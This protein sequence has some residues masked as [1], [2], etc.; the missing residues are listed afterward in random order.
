MGFEVYQIVSDEKHFSPFVCQ[1]CECLCSLD[2]LVTDACSHPFCRSCLESHVASCSQCPTCQQSIILTESSNGEE[3]I[4]SARYIMLGSSAT[5]AHPI[6][7]AQPLAYQLLCAVQVA[8][9][10]Q[11]SKT[12]A[13]KADKEVTMIHT[14]EWIGDYAHFHEHISEHHNHSSASDT[15]LAKIPVK[16]SQQLTS[17]LPEQNSKV[18]TRP[19]MKG[20]RSLSTPS[21]WSGEV[22]EST[23]EF[24]M[25]T[26]ATPTMPYRGDDSSASKDDSAIDM[27]SPR[28]K[29]R[30]S[31]SLKDM[32]MTKTISIDELRLNTPPKPQVTN[33]TSRTP[34]K[35]LGCDATTSRDTPPAMVHRKIS[36]DGMVKGPPPQPQPK[37]T[38][39]IIPVADE[40]FK[41]G[42]GGGSKSK[43]LHG[44]PSYS[45]PKR[46]KR[47][48]TP[49]ASA[50]AA[51]S[52]TNNGDSDLEV[53]YSHALDWNMSIN[54]FGGGFNN[55]NSTSDVN[56]NA[57]TR[58]QPAMDTLLEDEEKTDFQ[59]EFEPEDSNGIGSEQST[60]RIFDKAE[61]LKKQANAKFNKGDF[62]AARTLYT[63]GI[64][65]MQTMTAVSQEERELLSGMHSNRGVTYF[66][67]KKF[68]SCI[69]DCEHAIR[70]DST[71]DKSWIRKWRAHMAL[72][73]FDGAYHCLEKANR[74]IPASKKIQEELAN[75]QQ[76]KELL[77]TARQFLMKKDYE[78]IREVLRP[79][80]TS[81]DNISLLFL[82][83]RADA[84]L[85][86]TE[87]ALEKINKALRFNPMH[88]E[89][90][91]LRGHTLFLAGETEKGAHLLQEAL[92][93]NK[94]SK[95]INK[96]LS[97]CQ[98]THT[99]F[100]KGRASVKRGR[101]AEAVEHFAQAIKDSGNVP[102]QTPLFGSLRIERAEAYLL[103]NRYVDACK[104]CQEVINSQPEHATAWSVRADILVALGEPE[105]AKKELK[106]I[107]KSWG[108]DNPTIGEAFKRVD[109]ELRVRKADD[110]LET[111]LADLESGRAEPIFAEDD[112]KTKRKEG[113]RRN[114][115]S[116]SSFGFEDDID[117]KNRDK[118][119]NTTR[120]SLSR[121]RS[122]SRNESDNE[123][124]P[125]KPRSQSARR[126]EIQKRSSFVPPPSIE[127]LTS[128]DDTPVPER[129]SSTNDHEPSR[130]SKREPSRRRS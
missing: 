112:R 10:I 44:S 83:A 77:M 2:A 17:F 124:L 100:Q 101:Y 86:H 78:Q 51:P 9:I 90:L 28:A 118:K 70:Y 47:P 14:C 24:T 123:L 87:A 125:E 69:E 82:A 127:D 45:G 103:C 109:F 64:N 23:L 72:G 5:M 37:V 34:P 18:K 15:A 33:A 93:I 76:D 128:G 113:H 39:T 32:G 66:R 60:R 27:L 74:L 35:S 96:E 117:L 4:R 71:Y 62:S 26:E 58:K 59:L 7:T 111:F 121:N 3:T 19:T 63:V 91:E 40:T 13:L 98:K 95:L 1:L 22:S 56:E 55:N 116:S 126:S 105:Q 30:R 54:N 94:D 43:L 53:S 67:E 106:K 29:F 120:R 31:K 57:T 73:D 49:S 107:R 8:C 110:E 84:Y 48:L 89:G 65:V 50:A 79:H 6:K 52:S 115:R 92:N 75:C 16:T 68:Q 97:R 20:L 122:G 104:D 25:S 80:A 88:A 130:S 36:G 46:S 99:S 41:G 38:T 21:V 81:S 102:P 129:R 61:K 119:R 85:G 114:N 11:S 42:V 108:F 12:E